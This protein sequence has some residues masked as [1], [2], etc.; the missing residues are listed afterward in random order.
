MNRFFHQ[1]EDDFDGIE[2]STVESTVE[3]VNIT[4]TNSTTATTTATTKKVHLDVGKIVADRIPSEEIKLI[5][6]ALK[7]SHLSNNLSDS[8]FETMGDSVGDSIDTGKAVESKGEKAVEILNAI[9]HGRNKSV[10]KNN[11]TKEGKP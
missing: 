2:C 7:P 8:V 3:S 10:H 5:K 1:N 6:V 9:E 4:T 11:R